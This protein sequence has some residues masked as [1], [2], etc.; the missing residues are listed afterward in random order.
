MTG[1]IGHYGTHI[2]QRDQ[3]PAADN[4]PVVELAAVVVESAQ[5]PLGGGREVGL[6]EASVRQTGVFEPDFAEGRGAPEFGERPAPIGQPVQSSV[7]DTR[8]ARPGFLSTHRDG[9]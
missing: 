6:D 1:A 9:S 3:C 2:H 7:S 8:Q 4:G 5:N